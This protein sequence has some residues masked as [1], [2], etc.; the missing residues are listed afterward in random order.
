MM[1]QGVKTGKVDWTGDNPF[2]Y[3]KKDVDG[4]FSSLS[5]YFR[6]ASSDYGPGKAIL[7]LDN[8]YEEDAA[9]QLRLLVTDNKELSEFLVDNFVRFFGLFRKAVALDHLKVITDGV[10]TTTNEFP[11]RVVEAVRSESE[12][13]DIELHWDDLSQTAIAVDLAAHET[14]TKKH[15][16]MAVFYPAQS[17]QVLVN[18][19]PLEGQTIERDFN[20]ARAQSAALANSETWVRVID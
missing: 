18:G 6:I 9:N 20:G 7:V 8:P 5:V 2:I 10:F 1:I 3:L 12:D 13:L 17:A 11:K 4:D 19:E 15:E 16:M 14:Q